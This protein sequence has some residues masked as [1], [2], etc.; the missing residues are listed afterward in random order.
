MTTAGGQRLHVPQ[1]QTTFV[2]GPNNVGKSQLLRE[3]QMATHGGGHDGVIL[4]NAETMSRGSALDAV[5]WIKAHYPTAPDGRSAMPLDRGDSLDLSQLVREWK[6][7]SLRDRYLSRF[8]T[9]LCD[10]EYYAQGR[11]LEDKKATAITE[12]RAESEVDRL[13]KERGIYRV[14]DEVFFAAT[15]HH[16]LLR[17]PGDGITNIRVSPTVPRGRPRLEKYETQVDAHP[18]LRDQG[19]GWK[20]LALT[21]LTSTVCPTKLLLV[22]EPESYLH[23]PQAR[24]MGGHLATASRTGRQ[25]IVAT[26]SA[27][28]LQGAVNSG[29]PFNLWR[30]TRVGEVSTLYAA[31]SV[32]LRPVAMDPTIATHGAL[33]SVFHDGV[34]VCEGERD[35]SLYRKA[36]APDHR[37]F[38]FLSV[39]GV[40]AVPKTVGATRK[41]GVPTAAI[42]DFDVLLKPAN[43]LSILLKSF[44]IPLMEG[45][46]EL[47]RKVRSLAKKNPVNGR[48]GIQNAIDILSD[49]LQMGA[50]TAS[51][52][53]KIWAELDGAVR[54]GEIKRSGLQALSGDLRES[55]RELLERWGGYGLFVVPCGELESWAQGGPRDK[56]EWERYAT[57]RISRE[58]EFAALRRFV[59]SV[60]RWLTSPEAAPPPEHDGETDG[61]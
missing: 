13:R 6:N 48:S 2:V 9:L 39:G 40:H 54:G 60:E 18:L 19:T 57:A 10:V 20:S 26:H 21:I 38:L 16:L 41:M 11:P 49:R 1:D 56:I 59:R 22:D 28:I 5:A 15:G 32:V 34:V 12:W 46:L 8:V 3:L 45:D 42:V 7:P 50:V 52:R 4:S 36:G 44:D 25:V 51:D 14:V 31:E 35:A 29:R 61:P 30:L 23:P 37:E 24:L 47:S 43:Q 53:G 58:S 33:S 27:D 55:V 17:D